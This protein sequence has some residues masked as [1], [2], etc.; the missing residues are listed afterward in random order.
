EPPVGN[1]VVVLGD[2]YWRRTYG[3]DRS[4]IGRQIVI[5]E[6]PFTIIGIARAGFNGEQLAAVDLYVPLSALMRASDGTWMTNHGSHIISP[7]V[8]LRDGVALD[9]ARKIATGAVRGGAAGGRAQPSLDSHP[10]VAGTG[11]HQSAPS[12]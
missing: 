9:A 6:Q 11:T 10:V 3:A 5:G 2:A 1:P 7:V 4:V 12:P 8:R